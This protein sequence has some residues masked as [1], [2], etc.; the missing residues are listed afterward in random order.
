MN[1]NINLASQQNVTSAAGQSFGTIHYWIK[2]Q[3]KV[4][5]LKVEC[6]FDTASWLRI[7][8]YNQILGCGVITYVMFTGNW[9]VQ[10]N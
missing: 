10:C 8:M 5:I 4:S 9:V 6:G 1:V 3:L 7:F 2:S